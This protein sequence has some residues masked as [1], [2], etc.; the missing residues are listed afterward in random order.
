MPNVYMYFLCSQNMKFMTLGPYSR[1]GLTSNLSQYLR[2]GVLCNIVSSTTL[3]LTLVFVCISLLYKHLLV[4]LPL[5]QTGCDRTLCN[6]VTMNSR[7][8]DDSLYGRYFQPYGI[9]WWFRS[10]FKL[11]PYKMEHYVAYYS[12]SVYLCDYPFL[13]FVFYHINVKVVGQLWWACAFFWQP[14]I[15]NSCYYLW[16]VSVWQNKQFFVYY[17]R[18]RSRHHHHKA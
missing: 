18:Q 11:A 17:Y 13:F 6:V 12:L 3:A 15:V 4:G 16:L 14:A 10:S 1:R 5:H 9:V 7:H 2:D 8:T